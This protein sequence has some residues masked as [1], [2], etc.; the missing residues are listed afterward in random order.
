VRTRAPDDQLRYHLHRLLAHWE[1]ARDIRDLHASTVTKEDPEFCPR[2]Y[3]ILDELGKQPKGEF[4]TTAMQAT[5]S[6]GNMVQERV[7]RW[8]RL[9][10]L[11]VG[12]WRCCSC[13]HL[14]ILCRKPEICTDCMECEILDYEEPRFTSWVSGISCGIDVLVQLPTREKLLVV[15]VKSLMKDEF[16][17]LVMPEGRVQAPG[18]AAG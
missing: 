3:A 12:N 6:L 15:E 14:H 9:S 8:L 18:H 11:A 4:V 16:K 7:T 1:P 17:R 2:E 10:G 5:Y 13:E